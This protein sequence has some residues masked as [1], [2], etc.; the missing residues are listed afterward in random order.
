VLNGAGVRPTLRQRFR[1]RHR[2]RW[3][4]VLRP[5]CRADNTLI[6]TPN[7][8][9]EL[10]FEND[11]Q[12]AVARADQPPHLGRVDRDPTMDLNETKAAERLDDTLQW[13]SDPDRGAP[14]D[15]PRVVLRRPHQDEV[16]PVDDVRRRAGA[17]RDAVRA[18]D[19]DVAD[20]GLPSAHAS[21]H[22]HMRWLI[23]G[24]RHDENDASRTMAT[25]SEAIA[26]DRRREESEV[27]HR[28]DRNQAQC[29]ELADI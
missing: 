16:V 2:W 11:D 23:V 5:E 19:A 1:R 27:S 8:E 15:H 18:D 20:A 14:C 25:G 9:R 28:G 7:G 22:G 26:R 21:D 13:P 4:T 24:S 3:F 10:F 6:L 17:D 12:A 29:I